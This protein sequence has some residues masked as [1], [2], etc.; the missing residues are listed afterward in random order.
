EWAHPDLDDDYDHRHLSHLYPLWPGHEINPEDTP[1]LYS[2]A[3]K[4]AHLRKMGNESAHGLMHM[5]LVAAR[6]KDDAIISRN[7]SHLLTNDYLYSSLVTSHNP[8]H[9]IYNVDASCSLPA[10]VLEMLVYSRPGI[11]EVLPALPETLSKGSVSG[12]LCRGQ[13]R[14]DVLTWDTDANA[15]DIKLTSSKDQEITLIYRKGIK[16]LSMDG[17][18]VRANGDR[19]TLRLKAGQ[20][21]ILQLQSAE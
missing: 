16:A 7:L 14:V 9:R 21:H 10:I 20:Q 18:G 13:V 4:A 6:L 15:V 2:A 12:V 11:V 5:G 1:D 19:A 8:K 17:A 3:R